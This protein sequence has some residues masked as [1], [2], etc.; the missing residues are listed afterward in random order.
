VLKRPVLDE[1]GKEAAGKNLKFEDY[2]DMRALREV[3]KE[4]VFR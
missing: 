3:E 4:G 2:V 1:L